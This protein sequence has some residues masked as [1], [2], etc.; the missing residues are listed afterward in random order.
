M[1]DDRAVLLREAGEVEGAYLVA[2]ELGGHRQDGAGGD[3]AAA[4]DA[5]E[6][7]A[8]GGGSA[9]RLGQGGGEFRFAFL[10]VFVRAR[11]LRRAGDGD[12]AGA[13]AF[14]AGQIDVAAG[15]VDAALAAEFGLHRLD[16]DAAGLIRAVAAVLADRLVDHHALR[17]LGVFAG[18]APAALFGGA[19]LVVDQHAEAVVVAQLALHLVEFLAAMAGGAGGQGGGGGQAVLVVGDEGDAGDAFR[20][21]LGG[22]LGDGVAGLGGLAA[23]HGDRVVVEDL[24]GHAGL[25]RDRLADRE[26]AGMGVGAVADIGEQM[27]D[28]GEF[29][30]ADPGAAFAAHLGEGAGLAAVVHR[31]EMA[32]DAGGG[33]AA[34][35]Q[36]GGGTVRAAGAE[37][38]NAAQQAGGAFRCGRG[39]GLADVQPGFAEQLREA[40]ADDF[41]GQFHRRGEQLGAG[42]VGLADDV[43]AAVGAHVVE[44]FADLRLDEGALFLDH[45]QQA[46]AAGEVADAVGIDRPGEAELLH[47]EHR[48]LGDVQH[49]EGVHRVEMRPADGDDADRGVGAAEHQAVDV[50][51]AHPGADGGQAL[52]HHTAF[53]FGAIGGVAEGEID[54][55]AVRGQGVVGGEELARVGDADGGGLLGGF[56]GGFQR[57]PEAGEAGEGDAGEAEIENILGG[58]GVQHR[59]HDALEDVVGLVRVGG[60]MRGVIVT[61]Y[62]QHATVPGRAHKIGAAERIRGAVHTRALAVPH[63]EH[64]I[65]LLAREGVQLLGAKDH[66]GGHVLVQAGLKLDVVAVEQL[67][68]L[69]QLPVQAAE[70]RAAI[71]GD[72]AAC[73]QAGQHVQ[74]L[75]LQQHPHQRLDA[76]Q[77]HR[78]VEVGEP[79]LQRDARKIDGGK[80]D[81]GIHRDAPGRAKR[82]GCAWA[83]RNM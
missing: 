2:F 33:E 44:G 74:P 79:A 70:R 78:L 40:A 15:G 7:A 49:G 61:G 11:R 82:A 64:A 72:E 62:R 25:G 34:L 45:D 21:H 54:V 42:E 66:G 35:G 30:H 17:R 67:L 3:H 75:L 58:S 71:A 59:D 46:L 73:I 68:A 13:E 9:R 22:D 50:V 63:A 4:A 55:Q 18:F 31:H 10:P 60:G 5:G 43:R 12:E 76:G 38:G 69:P 19:D 26:Q 51:G 81:T 23:G 16:G 47:R 56:G 65:D 37:G 27:R 20:M 48:V 8:P 83:D 39:G 32:A 6:Q 57:G 77:Q 14:Q 28:V 36:L 80:I 1:G 41:R 29:R 24:V 52:I 53:E